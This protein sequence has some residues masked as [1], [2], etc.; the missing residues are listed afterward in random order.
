MNP[1]NPVT[2]VVKRGTLKGKKVPEALAAVTNTC[3]A[4]AQCPEVQADLIAQAAHAELQAKVAVAGTALTTKLQLEQELKTA[5][6]TLSKAFRQVKTS[7]VTYESS[8]NALSAGDAAVI[9]KAGLEARAE[10]KAPSAP[11]EKVLKVTSSP[12]QVPGQARIQWPA[13][14]GA[15]HF[16][17]QV[18]L[19]PQ[20]PAGTWTSLGTCARRTKLVTAASHEGQLL[21]RIAAIA[22]DGTRADW[23]DAILATAR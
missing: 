3:S 9:N 1:Q 6:K 16:E 10:A 21:V 7:L 14:P 8:V 22:S 17:I 15:D 23:S 2:S 18:N 4:G 13:T 11:V 5:E 12:G 19:T 20:D